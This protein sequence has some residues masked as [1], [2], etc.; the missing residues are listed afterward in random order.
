MDKG[1]CWKGGDAG[2]DKLLGR[3]GDGKNL[4][5]AED[6][7]IRRGGGGAGNGMR[8]RGTGDG[9]LRVLLLSFCPLCHAIH[10]HTGLWRSGWGG[11]E[12]VG[13]RR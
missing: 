9:M 5:K 10:S 1:D 8:D 6:A 3:D 11:A 13:R 4:G 2:K 7:L 12:R